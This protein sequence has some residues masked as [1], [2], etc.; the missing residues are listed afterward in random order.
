MCGDLRILFN[1]CGHTYNF[2]FKCESNIGEEAC[3]DYSAMIRI[4]PNLCQPTCPGNSSGE[5]YHLEQLDDDGSFGM[6]TRANE[7]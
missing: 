3:S 6:I 7:L 5:E 1:K 4:V 2:A